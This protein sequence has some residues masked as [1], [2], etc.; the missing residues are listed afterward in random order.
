M[1]SDTRHRIV[2]SARD[3]FWSQGYEATSLSDISERSSAKLGSIYYFFRTKADILEAVLDHY[4]H[5]LGAWLIDPVFAETD[6]AL[7]R[8]LGVI[9]TYRSFLVETHFTL[10]CP[11][12]GLA[13][14]VPDDLTTARQR[15]QTIFDSLHDTLT[16]C[17]ADPSLDG[18][19][20]PDAATL[21]A[22]AL[23]TIEGGIVQARATRSIEPFD[24]SVVALRDY[25]ARLWPGRVA[26][27]RGP[28]ARAS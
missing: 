23:T 13:I 22:L 16:E 14:E 17:L 9:E 18:H 3:L 2:D 11:V 28:R 7:E 24:R 6:D 10:G 27:A 26:A 19:D 5:Q 21:A 15:I 1:A 20:G 25:F 4:E 8:V 12:G